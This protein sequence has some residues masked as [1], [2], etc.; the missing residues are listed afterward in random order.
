MTNIYLDWASTTAEDTEVSKAAR[1]TARVSFGNPHPVISGEKRQ[2]LLDSA[3][4]TVASTLSCKSA[5]I[6]FTSGGTEANNI[7]F[8][9]SC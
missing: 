2:K 7:V 5:Q 6:V 4:I 3:R 8:R 9:V 1:N